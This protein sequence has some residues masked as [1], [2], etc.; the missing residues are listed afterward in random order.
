MLTLLHTADRE[1]GIEWRTY[2]PDGRVLTVRRSSNGWIAACDGTEREHARL[3]DAIRDAVG[4]DRGESLLIGR[5]NSE[6][7]EQWVQETAAH[8]MG[9]T[10]H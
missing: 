8:I 4:G 9:D 6:S 1:F 3:D 5:R 2:T 10:L 7:L